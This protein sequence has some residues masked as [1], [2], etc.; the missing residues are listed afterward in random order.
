[1]MNNGRVASPRAKAHPMKQL[2]YMDPPISPRNVKRKSKNKESK[3][4]GSSSS[5]VAD[6]EA[7][8]ILSAE[9]DFDPMG[10]GMMG[11]SHMMGGG[12]GG[13]MN[14]LHQ[15][16]YASYANHPETSPYA[17]AMS[18]S[19]FHCSKDFYECCLW[20]LSRSPTLSHK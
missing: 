8:S 14:V 7:N 19:V 3:N 16:S 1:M 12:G 18:V 5:S 13:M 11:G 17:H 6:L 10:G 2:P 15:N 9:Q 20:S 4:K